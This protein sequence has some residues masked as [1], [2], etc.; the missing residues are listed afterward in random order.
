[1]SVPH[2]TRNTRLQSVLELLKLEERFISTDDRNLSGEK[3]FNKA[4]LKDKDTD[5]LLQNEIKKSE[6]FLISAI[7]N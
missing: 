7:E 6:E 3:L 5:L 4:K 2:S 1:M